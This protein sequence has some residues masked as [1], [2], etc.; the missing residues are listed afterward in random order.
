MLL[1][2]QRWRHHHFAAMATSRVDAHTM[3][4]PC[5]LASFSPCFCCYY[6]MSLPVGLRPASTT[7][8]CINHHQSAVWNRVGASLDL[9]GQSVATIWTSPPCQ[10]LKQVINRPRWTSQATIWQ[11]GRHRVTLIISTSWLCLRVSN[12]FGLC[13]SQVIRSLTSGPELW[14]SCA[15]CIF[16]RLT[17]ITSKHWTTIHF[18]DCP[19]WKSWILVATGSVSYQKWSFGTSNNSR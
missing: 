3:W 6:T 8:R 13:C 11:C 2:H 4:P 16:W 19:L 12:V 9:Q 17:A 1:S 7:A 15:K 18:L 5:F 10:R 14:S